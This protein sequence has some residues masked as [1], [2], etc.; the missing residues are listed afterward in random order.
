[1]P[2][3]VFVRATPVP[4]TTEEKPVARYAVKIAAIKS[5]TMES[6]RSVEAST[7]ETDTMYGS[8]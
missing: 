5:P 2:A 7:V 1:M 8:T 4:S 3:L 6:G